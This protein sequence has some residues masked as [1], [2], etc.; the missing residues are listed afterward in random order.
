MEALVGLLVLILVAAPVVLTVLLII[1]Y[2][3]SRRIK[4]ILTRLDRL[5][6]LLQHENTFRSAPELPLEV[7]PVEPIRRRPPIA[8]PEPRPEPPPQPVRIAEPSPDAAVIEKWIGNRLGWLAVVVFVFA[9]AFFLKYAFDNNWIGEL[10]RVAIGVVVGAALCLAGF[11][12]HRKRGRVLR[13]ICTAAGTV[14]LYLST[15]AAFGF[16]SLLT[17]QEGGASS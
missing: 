3:R 11:A 10:G 16:Y 4:E 14:T 5:E 17:R 7:L 15:Y 13:D 2:V 9:A 12:S 8:T 1:A 6:H